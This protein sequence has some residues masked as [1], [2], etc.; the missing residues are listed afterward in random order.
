[1]DGRTGSKAYFYF[2]CSMHVLPSS[3]GVGVYPHAAPAENHIDYSMVT[4]PNPNEVTAFNY[5]HVYV[6]C[7]LGCTYNTQSW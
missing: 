6:K 2:L 4:L 3:H 1:M 7:K 5:M